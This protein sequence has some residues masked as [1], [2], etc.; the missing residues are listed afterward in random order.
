[1]IEPNYIENVRKSFVGN[2]DIDFREQIGSVFDLDNIVDWHILLLLTNNN[3]GI[4][5]NFYLYK[6]D[7]NTPIRIAPWDYDHSIGRDGDGELNLIRKELDIPR[8]MLFRR[9]IEWPAY[10][11]KLK[12]RW[13]EL[14]DQKLLRKED[15]VDKI[16]DQKKLVDSLVD[17]N[18]ERWP[19][20]SEFYFDDNDFLQE[21]NVIEEYFDLRYPQ[22]DVYFD[23]L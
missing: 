11:A 6:A 20:D 22:L 18:F 1:M 13:L 7:S 23:S 9:L 17:K 3:D 2:S 19:V 21:I 12:A 15:V 4:L 14:K 16:Y 10:T 5:K 8:S